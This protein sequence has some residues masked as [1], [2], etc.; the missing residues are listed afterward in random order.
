MARMISTLDLPAFESFRVRRG[1]TKKAIARALDLH[2][3]TLANSL[4]RA[5]Q[6]KPVPLALVCLLAFALSCQPGEL[7]TDPI[8]IDYGDLR[9]NAPAA[10]AKE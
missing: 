2:V 5:R 7:M 1:V 3:G 9:R 10:D 6:G 4:T 8:T